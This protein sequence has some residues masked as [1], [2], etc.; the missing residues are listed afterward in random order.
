M[1]M[2]I[3]LTTSILR[4]QIC[5]QIYG[6]NSLLSINSFSAQAKSEQELSQ[7][8]PE[9]FKQEL[10]QRTSGSQLCKVSDR[11]LRTIHQ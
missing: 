5:T 3:L 10:Q 2:P 8:I 11:L 6:V 9:I 7:D 1:A 4:T